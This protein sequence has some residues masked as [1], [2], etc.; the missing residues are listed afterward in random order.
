MLRHVLWIILL[1]PSPAFN[2]PLK[3]YNFFLGKCLLPDDTASD[4]TP[5]EDLFFHCQK[6]N[7]Q[8]DGLFIPNMTYGLVSHFD[9]SGS[10]HRGFSHAFFYQ[11]YLEETVGSKR[12]ELPYQRKVIFDTLAYQLGNPARD[13]IRMIVGEQNSGFGINHFP[14]LGYQQLIDPRDIWQM[15]RPAIT[16]VLDN[17]VASQIEVGWHSAENHLPIANVPKDH[18]FTTRFTHDF[19][20]AE[21][22][23]TVVSIMVKKTGE[24]RIGFG[25]LTRGPKSNYFQAEFVRIYPSLSVP[26]QTVSSGTFFGKTGI[27]SPYQQLIRL[28]YEDPPSQHTRFTILYD[29]L[30]FQYRLL[31]VGLSWNVFSD[32]S[33]I[34]TLLAFK[35]DTSGKKRS[36]WLLGLGLGL[37]L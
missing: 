11:V 3:S 2:A 25:L 33:F 37:Y 24:R 18:F 15:P 27:D 22:T 17:Q 9:L 29:D 6:G 26:F 31:A 12:E 20:L 7:A 10:I 16:L 36:R 14:S 19:A 5:L 28:S 30:S 23:R 13:R 21:S 35:Q 4:S 34:R 1:F 32:H 8:V